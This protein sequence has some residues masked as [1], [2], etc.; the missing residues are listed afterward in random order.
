MLAIVLAILARGGYVAAFL[1]ALLIGALATPSFLIIGVLGI[2]T[3]P[4]LLVA[5]LLFRVTAE[6]APPGGGW[7][8]WPVPRNPWNTDAGTFLMHS[9]TYVDE[10]ALVIVSQWLAERGQAVIQQSPPKVQPS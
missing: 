1:G 9:T 5:A 8:V 7:P 3:G 10:E 2:A 6:S 4:E